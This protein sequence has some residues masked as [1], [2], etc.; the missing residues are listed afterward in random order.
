[1]NSGTVCQGADRADSFLFAVTSHQPAM[2]RSRAHSA[3][4]PPMH[5]NEREAS[6]RYR[7]SAFVQRW[8]GVLGA[9]LDAK[10]LSA[11]RLLVDEQLADGVRGGRRIVTTHC[12]R[13]FRQSSGPSGGG[14]NATV[15]PLPKRTLCN[16]RHSCRRT[17][18]R[19]PPIRR[20]HENRRR[21]A[22]PW[23]K[24]WHATTDRASERTT[25][26]GKRSANAASKISSAR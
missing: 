18:R 10:V 9:E 14:A 11:K 8:F 7:Q 15:G 24:R 4:A 23:P 26:P 6:E 12:W 21:Q 22:S 16:W 20:L 19:C 3:A 5:A 13:R 25:A 17:R 1:M 2:A